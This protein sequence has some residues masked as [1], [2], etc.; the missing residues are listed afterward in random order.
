MESVIKE[1]EL[2]GEL[3]GFDSNKSFGDISA[4]VKALV[5]PH[6]V[7]T[8]IIVDDK[9]VELDEELVLNE[10]FFKDLGRVVLKTRDVNELFRDSLKMAPQICEALQMD[11]CDVE[12]F[13]VDGNLQAAQER[14]GEMTS[15]L[16]WLLQLISGLQSLGNEKI[17]SMTFSQ[18]KV[19]DSVNRM[20]FFLAKLHLN[21]AG[22]QWTE[23]RTTMNGDFKKEV[24]VWRMLF[25]EVSKT[26]TP[27]TSSLES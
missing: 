11:C 13:F 26:W 10:T 9:N 27:R 20:Q 16:E 22:Q 19:M 1:L 17:E 24:G 25:E 4:E 23:F 5:A 3:K 21:L 15:L 8:E 18:G 14:V 6:R 2:D 7:V 12:Q